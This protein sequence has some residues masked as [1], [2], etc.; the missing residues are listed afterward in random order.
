LPKCSFLVI[1]IGIQDDNLPE[2]DETLVVQLM[3][4]EGGVLLDARNKVNVVI[5]AND[6]VAGV[7]GF[8]S[9]SYI[10]KEG[11]TYVTQNF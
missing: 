10:A 3:Q 7:V 4:P 6:Y 9:S 2:H 1:T 8:T 5:L 11:I